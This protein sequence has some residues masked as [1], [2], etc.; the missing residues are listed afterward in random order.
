MLE[1]IYQGKNVHYHNIENEVKVNKT[2]ESILQWYL[3]CFD[4]LNTKKGLIF[5]F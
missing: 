3:N 1:D 4:Q 2:L 5:F